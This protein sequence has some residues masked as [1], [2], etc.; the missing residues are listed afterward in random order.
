M[1]VKS[2][3]GMVTGLVI[4]AVQPKEL[5]IVNLVGI[6]DPAKIGRLSGQLGIPKIEPLEAGKGGRP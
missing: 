4:I 3:K 5:T 1:F 2:E 6:I